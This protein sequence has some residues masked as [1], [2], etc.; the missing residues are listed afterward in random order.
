MNLRDVARE[1]IMG[2]IEGIIYLLLYIYLLPLLV[3]YLGVLAGQPT[4]ESA[5]SIP[6]ASL[7]TYIAVFEALSV[8]SRVMR[9]SVFSPIFRSILALMGLIVVL[10]ILQS[11]MP[12]GLITSTYAYGQARYYLSLS[13]YPLIIIFV[14]FLVLP[15]VIMPFIDHYIYGSGS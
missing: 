10:Y 15:G 2:V 8:A 3:S 11:V 6:V 14:A 12:G 4:I 7:I 1:A 13:V 9:D 5:Y